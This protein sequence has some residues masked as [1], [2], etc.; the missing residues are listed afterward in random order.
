MI[1]R[2]VEPYHRET[3]VT[4]SKWMIALTCA[5]LAAIFANPTARARAQGA[6]EILFNGSVTNTEVIETDTGD[7]VPVYFEVPREGETATYGVHIET[8][9]SNKQIKVT[10]VKKKGPLTERGDCPKCMGS[11]KCQGCYPAG[12]GVNT[13]GGECYS[14]NATGDCPF[15]QGSGDCYTCGGGGAPTGCYTCGDVSN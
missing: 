15:C 10:R 8:D 9:A 12:S 7:M 2:S 1:L 3:N 6:W 5:M 14:C 13:S 11:K 4:R